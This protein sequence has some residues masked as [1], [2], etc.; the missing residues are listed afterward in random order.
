MKTAPTAAYEN[1]G[2]DL[3][4]GGSAQEENQAGGLAM[5]GLGGTLERAS[6]VGWGFVT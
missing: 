6:R 1:F 5:R 2:A 4:G 3:G